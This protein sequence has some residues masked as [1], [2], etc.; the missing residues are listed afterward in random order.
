M[1]NQMNICKSSSNCAPS[2]AVVNANVTSQHCCIRC[3]LDDLV[4]FKFIV[5]LFNANRHSIGDYKVPFCLQSCSKP[6]SYAM[7]VNDLGSEL[8]HQYVGQEPSG[9]AFNSLAL[10]S[11]NKPHNPMIN[12]GALITAS[13]L[14]SHLALPDKFDYVR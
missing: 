8:V 14:R 3:F 6:M 5:M 13:L 1:S 4:F 12:A 9:Q 10:D 2:S 11:T 7:A